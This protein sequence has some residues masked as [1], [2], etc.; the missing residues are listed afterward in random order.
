M[1]RRYFTLTEA[2]DLVPTLEAILGRSIQLHQLLRNRVESLAARGHEVNE[3]LL[4]GSAP[5][6]DGAEQLLAEARGLYATL[7]EDAARIDA[8]GGELKGPDLVDFWSWEEGRR[9]VLLCWKLGERSIEW[10]HAEEA[11]FAGRQRVAGHRFTSAR[12]T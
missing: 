3:K 7:L 6:P 2:Q 1:P 12:E 8:L 10:F 5:A 11:G 9:E 4:A